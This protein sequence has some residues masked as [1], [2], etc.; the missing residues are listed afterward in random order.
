VGETL[1]MDTFPRLYSLS[2]SKARTISEVG[3]WVNNEGGEVFNWQ[4][5]WRKPM[6]SG[7]RY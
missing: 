4:L 5:L 3:E 6:F 7:R 2:M 1:L